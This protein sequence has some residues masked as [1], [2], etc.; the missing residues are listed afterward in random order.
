MIGLMRGGSLPLATERRGRPR[1]RERLPTG[2]EKQWGELVRRVDGGEA[3]T[4][5]G[6]RQGPEPVTADT[7]PRGLLRISFNDNLLCSRLLYIF[8]I[9][10]TEKFKNFILEHENDD[11]ARLLLSKGKWK[12]IDT[13]LAAN[14]IISRKKLKGKVPEWYAEAGLIFPSSL[15]AEQC[16][17]QATAE[18][19]A[20]LAR[21][22]YQET[23]RGSTGKAGS[24]GMRIA[25][26]TGGLGVDSR[27]FSKT[28][29]HVLYNEMNPLLADAAAHNFRLLGAGNIAVSCKALEP[30]S[31]EGI[32]GEADTAGREE[33]CQDTG[34]CPDIIYLDPARR[35]D[36][37]RKVF[38]LEDCRPDILKLKEELLAK[39]RFVIVK[40]SPM[41]DISMVTDRLGG[42]CR[43]MHIVSS[44][45]ECKE[46]LAV[47]DREYSGECVTVAACNAG[48]DN[49]VFT[50]CPSEEKY[51][52]A[53]FPASQDEV[54][55]AGFLFEP[56]KALMK[57]GAFN[58]ISERFHITKLSRNTH[59]YIFNAPEAAAGLSG[60][61]KVYTILK[62]FPM[63]KAGIRQ[64]A[65]EFQEAE[66]TAR[67]IHMSSEQLRKR[68]GVRSGDRI[69]IFGAEYLI[70][71][72]R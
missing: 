48:K 16:S 22:L 37:G 25:D 57:S 39:A 43:E 51:A 13:G 44:G 66:V 62:V 41:A 40:L 36:A 61:G 8:A 45:G 27:A 49:A 9:M 55:S 54:M 52:S 47:L 17:S 29:E 5:P 23:L 7:S 38:L 33:N 12:D 46:L 1:P 30:G 14:T 60:Y 18:Y 63:N 28:A 70:V 64:A 26:L 72:E 34:F 71:T 10:D 32:L 50:F 65:S 24:G 21:R 11:P 6:Q 67:N 56:D 4:F 69:H 20:R 15:S 19:K 2:R 35:D 68:L 42:H 58:L 59:L 3:G 53:E 31:L